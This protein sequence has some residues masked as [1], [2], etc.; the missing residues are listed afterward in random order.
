MLLI[1]IRRKLKSDLQASDLT[2]AGIRAAEHPREGLGAEVKDS[3]HV[4]LN[5]QRV[6]DPMERGTKL[7]VIDD[8]RAFRARLES[9]CMVPPLVWSSNLDIGESMRGVPLGNLG[10]PAERDSVDTNS[11]I[12]QRAA[13]HLDRWRGQNAEA[14]PGRCDRV[15]VAGVGEER[16]GRLERTWHDGFK[17][18]RAQPGA[19]TGW[20]TGRV[21]LRG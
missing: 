3:S 1:Q 19:R 14:Y 9:V 6:T 5:D 8:P 12:D 17:V 11:I 2:S 21:C 18:K 7:N 16:K 4:A 13:P 10:A 15:Q 20:S